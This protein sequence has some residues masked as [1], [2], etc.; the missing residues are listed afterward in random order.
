MGCEGAAG[1]ELGGDLLEFEEEEL[2]FEAAGDVDEEG[3]EGVGM[4]NTPLWSN[5]DD[6]GNELAI[7]EEGAASEDGGADGEGNIF[8]EEASADG[9]EEGGEPEA[10][11][12]AAAAASGIAFWTAF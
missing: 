3:G 12:L 9:E 6:L 4:I 10:A 1:C 2:E 7:R 8:G 11:T 5:E